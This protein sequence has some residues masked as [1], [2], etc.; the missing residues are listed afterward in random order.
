MKN[1]FCRIIMILLF[2]QAIL[3]CKK[4][5]I[6]KIIIE[7]F[8]A[9]DFLITPQNEINFIGLNSD[10]E[11]SM[12]YLN[13]DGSINKIV[14]F[15]EKSNLPLRIFPTK[16]NPNDFYL[17]TRNALYCIN[18]EMIE[19]HIVFFHHDV[20]IYLTSL[21]KNDG[22]IFSFSNLRDSI[23]K[24]SRYAQIV[25][26]IPKNSFDFIS[27]FISIFPKMYDV[28]PISIIGQNENAILLVQLKNQGEYLSYYALIWLSS[29]NLNSLKTIFFY[30]ENEDKI[31]VKLIKIDDSKFAVI[32]NYSSKLTKDHDIYVHIFEGEKETINFS[33]SGQEDEMA[34]DAILTDDHLYI[35]GYINKPNG[36]TDYFINKVNPS[37]DVVWRKTFEGLYFETANKIFDPGDGFLYILG[38]AKTKWHEP[39]RKWLCKMDK[40]G[41]TEWNIQLPI[42]IFSI[43]DLKVQNNEIKLLA[44]QKGEQTN[45]PNL[46]LYVLNNNGKIKYQNDFLN[47]NHY[48]KIYP[49][50]GK[51]VMINDTPSICIGG[52]YEKNKRNLFHLLALT[53]NDFSQI[54]FYYYLSNYPMSFYPFWAEPINNVLYVSGRS[55]HERLQ[56][57]LPSILNIN[58]KNGNWYSFTVPMSDQMTIWVNVTII[59]DDRVITLNKNKIRNLDFYNI[60]EISLSQMTILKTIPLHLD[61]NLVPQSLTYIN[62]QYILAGYERGE[63]KLFLS[64]ISDE[65]TILET[66]I[67][68]YSMLEGFNPILLTDGK[69]I[70]VG[71]NSIPDDENP[72]YHP[73]LLK[74]SSRLFK[75]D[76]INLNNS[77]HELLTAMKLTNSDQLIFTSSP[78]DKYH[79]DYLDNEDNIWIPLNMMIPD[80][81]KISKTYVYRV[82]TSTF[83]S[84]D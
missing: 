84:V 31:P 82:Y 62:N 10:G 36:E 35:I 32:E 48:K 79:I 44:I 52:F 6:S 34:T 77:E 66:Q 20:D 71:I 65:G 21:C 73:I 45:R 12:V 68:Q 63:K 47:Q 72:Y 22:S 13:P 24:N 58:L 59:N 28:H 4:K 57:M 37:G 74:F 83:D 23:L 41:Q 19:Y 76:V 9:S 1:Y 81:E 55:Y 67:T 30:G 5:E 3:S 46:I 56:M 75:K 49:C 17:N 50:F 7:D 42:Q 80:R 14:N 60:T 2:I 43:S 53:E 11:L 25:R 8:I 54:Y 64:R 40:N 69:Y 27:N 78:V 33:I 70:Y 38:E 61:T 29:K 16:S 51:F 26:I 39:P 18:P 15:Y